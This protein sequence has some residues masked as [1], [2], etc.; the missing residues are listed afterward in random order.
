MFSE[1]GRRPPLVRHF[2]GENRLGAI[3]L[4]VSREREGL[5]H[6]KGRNRDREHVS[7]GHPVID[8][9]DV[10]LRKTIGAE[11]RAVKMQRTAGNKEEFVDTCRIRRKDVR[12][13][14]DR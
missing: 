5:Q 7:A 12:S 2:M 8:L 3:Q 9:D 14:G 11:C 13:H 1:H 6:D 4:I 10:K